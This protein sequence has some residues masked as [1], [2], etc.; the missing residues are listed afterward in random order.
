[1]QNQK[2]EE[3]RKN[4]IKLRLEEMKKEKLAKKRE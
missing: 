1:L 2:E 4:E 3:E